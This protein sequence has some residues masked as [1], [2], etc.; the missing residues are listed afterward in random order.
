[1]GSLGTLLAVLAWFVGVPI[2]AFGI[3]R[4]IRYDWQKPWLVWRTEAGPLPLWVY[5]GV[6]AFIGLGVLIATLT[7]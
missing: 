6:S 4:F 7:R 5:L 2:L 1:M 3:L